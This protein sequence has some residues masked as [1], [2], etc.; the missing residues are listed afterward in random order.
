MIFFMLMTYTRNIHVITLQEKTE[1]MTFS[2]FMTYT[3]NHT[4][5]K[6]VISDIFYVSK[7]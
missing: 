7:R 5:R 4:T 2:M 1:S 6:N 3:N